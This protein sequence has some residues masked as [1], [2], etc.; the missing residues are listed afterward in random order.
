MAVPD[1][2]GRPLS[3]LISLTK[4]VAVVT[5]GADGI[6]HAIASRFAEAGA[7]VVVADLDFA[8]AQRT[9]EKLSDRYQRKCI[10]VYADV[11]SKKSL[12]DAAEFTIKELG[13]LD[14]WVNN[15]GV[16]PVTPVLEL[17]EDQ[18]E[19]VMAVNLKGTFLG[20]VEAA[21]NMIALNRPGVIINLSSTVGYRATMTGWAD[22]AA[23]KHGVR[24]LTKALSV[25]LASYG[26]RVLALA[27]TG[28]NT[29]GIRRS[30]QEAEEQGVDLERS[31][32]RSI[33]P[34]GREGVPDDIARVA[35]FCASDLSLLM[36]G[37]TLLVD[38]GTLAL[39]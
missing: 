4:R 9:T 12:Q 11:S 36:T 28:T 33:K 21:K 6:G 30:E 14:V 18:W 26:I 16:Y 37:S 1:V 20:S 32:Q 25:Q 13:S 17:T 2:T 10:G 7:E 22:Y 27:P 8:K 19:H 5:G 23:A 15:A 29:P 35:L 31:R 39:L 24:G 34:L 3:E 38:G